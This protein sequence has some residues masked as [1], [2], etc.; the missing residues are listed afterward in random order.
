MMMFL[1]LLKYINNVCLKSLQ[2]TII[3]SSK[4]TISFTSQMS[5]RIR[6]TTNIS[7]FRCMKIS[8]QKINFVILNNVVRSVFFL[9]LQMFWLS[10]FKKILNRTWT[11]WS[12]SRKII[13]MSKKIIVKTILFW[14]RSLIITMFWTKILF[15]FFESFKKYKFFK[16]NSLFLIA[17]IITSTTT[18]WSSF[19]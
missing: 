19:N 6:L 7:N 10:K 14:N 17:L 15:V 13:T 8:F 1:N 9:T 11:I 5:K 2:N 12:S 3:L 16:S 18:R 4:K